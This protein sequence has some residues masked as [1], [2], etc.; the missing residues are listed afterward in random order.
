MKPGFRALL[1]VLV[2]A[3]AGAAIAASG[4]TDPEATVVEALIVRGHQPGPA[5]WK[6]SNATATVYV[7]GV[8]GAIPKG[9]AWD[10]SVVERRVKGASEVILPPTVTAGVGDAAALVGMLGSLRSSTPMEDALPP[11]LKARYEADRARLPGDPR[12]YSHWLPAV[13]GLQMVGDWRKKLDLDA[14]EPAKTVRHL[15]SAEGVKTIP[16]GTYKALPLFKAMAAQ[17]GPVGPVCVAD[18]LDEI[19]AGAGPVHA[20]AEG[21]ARGDVRAALTEQ[22]GYEKCASNF[23]EGANIT[24][25]ATRDTAVAI[26]AALAK[27]GHSIAVVNLRALLAPGG[28]LQQLQARGFKVAR[29]DE[30]GD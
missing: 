23:P 7:F 27:P 17:A 15:A 26:A 11:A 30:V 18:A 13:A 10:Q 5:W 29:P 24:R 9:M 25:V 8:P 6:V 12:G 20:A 1:V 22:R 19:E 2:A 3:M 14:A 21:W 28:V 4:A 16:A